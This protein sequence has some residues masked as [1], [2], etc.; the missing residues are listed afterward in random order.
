MSATRANNTL[1][2]VGEKVH[3]AGLHLTKATAQINQT[4]SVLGQS[5]IEDPATNE[6]RARAESFVAEIKPWVARMATVLRLSE[7]EMIWKMDG[8]AADEA[9]VAAIIRNET[10]YGRK[11]M[12]AA[13]MDEMIKV[14]PSNEIALTHIAEQGYAIEYLRV[15]EQGEDKD[16]VNLPARSTDGPVFCYDFTSTRLDA[17]RIIKALRMKA[18]AVQ[19]GSGEEDRKE[20]AQLLDNTR[21]LFRAL[22][23]R[24]GEAVCFL[25]PDETINRSAQRIRIRVGRNEITA[26]ATL[27]VEVEELLGISIPFESI[28]TSR[29]P[30][31]PRHKISAEN[32]RKMISLLRFILATIRYERSLEK[33]QRD[34]ED[35]YRMSTVRVEDFDRGKIGVAVVLLERWNQHAWT[36]QPDGTFLKGEFI[37]THRNIPFAVERNDRHEIRLVSCLRHHEGLF[38]PGCREFTPERSKVPV[39]KVQPYDG[40]NIFGVMLRGIHFNVERDH[41]TTTGVQWLKPGNRPAKSTSTPKTSAAP[42]LKADSATASEK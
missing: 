25:P 17:P 40:L 16:S 18:A 1:A 35:L 20:A 21:K 12:E 10:G 28:K 34:T 26:I 27:G 41:R 11:M 19:R 5:S 42:L 6:N 36:E 2:I 33:I 30:N 32:W 14:F 23:D 8:L 29:L 39:P 22:K 31:N 37:K 7:E 13:Y 9:T 3:D 15:L 38:P 24:S 4:T